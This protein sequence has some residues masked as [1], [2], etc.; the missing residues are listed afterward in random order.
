MVEVIGLEPTTFCMPSRRSP[1]LSYTPTH[2][3]TY[4]RQKL[5]N[6]NTFCHFA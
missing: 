6:V 4:Y 3:N 5:K 2:T 1:K